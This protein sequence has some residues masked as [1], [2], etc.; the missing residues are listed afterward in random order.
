MT[1]R[2]TRQIAECYQGQWYNRNYWRTWKVVSDFGRQKGDV[3]KSGEEWDM[4][5]EQLKALQ[6]SFN[7]EMIKS[8][9]YDETIQV[10]HKYFKLT[11]SART[12]ADN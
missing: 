3:I 4:L 9:K 1:E 10:L 7:E 12:A 11:K 8:D 2:R 6:Q 5:M